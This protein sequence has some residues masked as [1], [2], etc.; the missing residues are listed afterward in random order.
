MTSSDAEFSAAVRRTFR[1][2]ERIAPAMGDGVVPV[3]CDNRDGGR[4]LVGT[5]FFVERERRSFLVTALHNFTNNAG[6][7]LKIEFSGMVWTL[8][9]MSGRTSPADDLWVA[10]ADADLQQR[11]RAINVPLLK[12]DEPESCQFGTGTVL[13]GYPEDLSLPG[14]PFRPLAISTT[15]DVRDGLATTS[16]L[17]E[18]IIYNVADDFLSTAEGLT[19]MHRPDIFGM[20]GGPA[21]S[22]FCTAVPSS[23]KAAFNFFL[24]GMIVSWQRRKGYVVACNAARIAALITAP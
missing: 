23:N 13:M 7:I 3:W 12:R 16:T 8:S 19:V 9:E 18:P 10:E 11:L 2:A 22:W 21:F 20:S 6:A 1:L 4:T 14:A 15:L 5:A 24:Q 17:P